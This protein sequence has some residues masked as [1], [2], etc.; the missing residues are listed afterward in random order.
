VTRRVTAAREWNGPIGIAAT[1]EVDLAG[2]TAPRRRRRRR[3]SPTATAPDAAAA[4]S[5]TATN[6]A[7]FQFKVDRLIELA[8]TA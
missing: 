6:P 3:T 8:S 5:A 4:T 2:L 7:H 1:P